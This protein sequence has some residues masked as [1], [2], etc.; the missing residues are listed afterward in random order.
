M[1]EFA[2]RAVA[3]RNFIGV[4]RFSVK[5]RDERPPLVS[6]PPLWGGDFLRHEDLSIRWVF[7]EEP[8][9]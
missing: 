1:I 4:F 8:E 6:I 5:W 9:T 2:T 7:W 3:R